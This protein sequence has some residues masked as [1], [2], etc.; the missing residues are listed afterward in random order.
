MSN[1]LIKFMLCL[2]LVVVMTVGGSAP[3]FAQDDGPNIAFFNP[4]G[5]NE[6]TAA[7]E[8]GAREVIEANGGNMEVFT[9]SFDPAEQLNQIQD[10]ITSGNFDAFIIYPIDGIG[11]T[12]GVD[13]AAEAGIQV[14]ALDAVIGPDIGTLVPYENVAAQVARTATGDG[15]ALADAMVMACEGVDPCEVAFL[16]GFSSFPLD[17]ERLAVVQARADASD[18]IE[19]VAV[20]DALYLEDEGFTVATDML[21]ANPDIDAFVS[22][23]DQMILGAELAVQDAGLEG[24]VALIGQGGN[25]DA[26]NAVAEGRWFATVANI[27]YTNGRI[28]GQMAIQALDGSLIVRSVNMYDQSPPFPSTGPIITQDNYELFEP[29]W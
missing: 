24:Q 22:V 12:V 14:I 1:L 21:Q 2:A 9:A 6:Y 3:L 29:E 10:A 17:V 27:P 11:V 5:A 19:I 25:Q 18:N 15:G 16:Q 28:A 26:Y 4:L 7:T 8:R 23:G 13:A 20:Q